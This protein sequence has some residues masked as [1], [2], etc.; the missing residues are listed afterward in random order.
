MSRCALEA[1]AAVDHNSP[2]TGG[3]IITKKYFPIGGTVTFKLK[4]IIGINEVFEHFLG[5]RT[6]LTSH[7]ARDRMLLV[8]VWSILSMIPGF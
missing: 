5:A 7:R 2:P 8:A 1:P 6:M 4:Y 3:R